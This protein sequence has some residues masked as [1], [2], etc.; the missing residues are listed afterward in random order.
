M[1]GESIEIITTIIF[2]ALFYF[3]YQFNKK[4]KAKN[5]EGRCFFI[6]AGEMPENYLANII[7]IIGEEINTIIR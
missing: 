4:Q 5:I 1:S 7:D 3:A 6:D 2:F